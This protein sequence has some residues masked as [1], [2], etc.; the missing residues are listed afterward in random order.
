[1]IP[2]VFVV[3]DLGNLVPS[4]F[5]LFKMWLRK[6][7]GIS[8]YKHDEISSFFWITIS[9]CRKQAGFARRWRQPPKKPFHHVSCNKILHDSWSISAALARGFSGRHF[10]WGEGPGGDEVA[11]LEHFLRFTLVTTRLHSRPSTLV[12]RPASVSKSLRF[13]EHYR[14]PPSGGRGPLFPSS[15]HTS[16][17]RG[18]TETRKNSA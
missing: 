17:D 6:F 3:S 2:V 15:C 8:S 13:G 7:F 4:A 5:P 14:K 10:E 16:L 9:D 12:R 18:L 11:I 1:M